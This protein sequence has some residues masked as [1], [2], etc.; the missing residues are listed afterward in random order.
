MTK[1]LFA[2]EDLQGLLLT[3]R[4]RKKRGRNLSK[5]SGSD[6]ILREVANLVHGLMPLNSSCRATTN[7]ILKVNP[8]IS[9]R[10][11]D[12]V[13]AGYAKGLTSQENFK[14]SKPFLRVEHQ[15]P[16]SAIYNWIT[17][18]LDTIT[19]EEIIERIKKFPPV[20]ILKEEDKRLNDLKL[21]Y[22]TGE[23]RYRQAGISVVVLDNQPFTYNFREIE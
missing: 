21:R 3:L 22:T 4:N 11:K 2:K 16:I 19:E 1:E 23:N 7:V 14:E 20:T 6:Y 9:Q 5:S 15:D 13:D 10:A 17:E 12:L 8:N 18:N